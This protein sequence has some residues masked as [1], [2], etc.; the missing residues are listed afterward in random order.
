MLC[1]FLSNISSMFTVKLQP[2]RRIMQECT[3]PCDKLSENEAKTS[4]TKQNTPAQDLHQIG[5]FLLTEIGLIKDVLRGKE[6]GWLVCVCVSVCLCLCFSKH[7]KNFCLMGAFLPQVCVLTTM[8]QFST[9]LQVFT[10]QFGTA[11]YLAG[12]F[13]K[14]SMCTYIKRLNFKSC[15]WYTSAAVLWGHSG[16]LSP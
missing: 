14:Y 2:S 7:S 15:K 4:Q 13:F 1:Y 10:L 16:S 8:Q 3:W 12:V 11:T 6:D 5:L 9:Q